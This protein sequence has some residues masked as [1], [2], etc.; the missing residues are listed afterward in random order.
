MTKKRPPRVFQLQTEVAE[1]SAKWYELIGKDHHKDHDCHFYIEVIWSYGTGPR[2]VPRHYG[3]IVDNDTFSV[4]MPAN[5]PYGGAYKEGF[6]SYDSALEWMVQRVKEM[7]KDEEE[8]Q[9]SEE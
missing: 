7:I 3:Y 8:T 4:G 2:F 5:V 1:L 6:W 9:A